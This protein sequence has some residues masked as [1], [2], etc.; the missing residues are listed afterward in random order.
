MPRIPYPDLTKLEPKV[1]KML[2]GT[3]INVV[4]MAAHAS[5]IIFE[6]GGL[7]GYGIS[8]PA[9]L[10]PRVRETVIL[11]VAYISNSKYELYQHLSI[12]QAVGLTAEEIAA[13]GA[14]Q[15]DK[16]NPLLATV[17]R[18][19]DDVVVNVSPSDDNLA[20]LRALVSDRVLVNITMTIGQYMNVARLIAVTGP[21]IDDQAL[22][23]LPT[24]IEDQAR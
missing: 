16:L 12:A 14:V 6:A 17:A 2:A 8:D 21:D 22:K 13:I 24:D 7:M 11:R 9:N 15:Y 20:A 19:T 10:D 3:P 1:Q 5:P 18:F 4:R 23:H